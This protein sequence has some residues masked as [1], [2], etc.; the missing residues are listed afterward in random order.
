MG[1]NRSTMDMV[2]RAQGASPT[3]VALNLIRVRAHLRVTHFE[4]DGHIQALMDLAANEVT[5]IADGAPPEMKTQAALLWIAWSYSHRGDG[6][7]DTAVPPN[8]WHKCGALS[9]LKPWRKIR[10]GRI[11]EAS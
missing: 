8:S 4:E 1:L 10:A 5:R 3:Q 7:G 6:F 11:Q 2:M 9:L